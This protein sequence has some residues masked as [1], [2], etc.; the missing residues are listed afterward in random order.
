MAAEIVTFHHDDTSKWPKCVTI[1]CDGELLDYWAV[2]YDAI[3]DGLE[4]MERD[5]QRDGMAYTDAM[6]VIGDALDAKLVRKSAR[7]KPKGE[8]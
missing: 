6:L 8:A 2:D 5:C 1:E 7:I 3:V 4:M